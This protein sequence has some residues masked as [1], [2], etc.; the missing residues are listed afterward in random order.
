MK[1]EILFQSSEVFQPT[2]KLQMS[3][4]NCHDCSKGNSNG[5]PFSC[6]RICCSY[7]RIPGW[8]YL[9][10]LMVKAKIDGGGDF[11][12]TV[13]DATGLL[14]LFLRELPDP[15]LTSQFYHPF[16]RAYKLPGA[17]QRA[18][19]ILLLCLSLPVA[20]LHTL[21]FL[22]HLLY[23]VVHSKDSLMSASNLA[24]IFTPNIL[25]PHV[26]TET[27]TSELELA[28]HGACVGVV[29]FLIE[30]FDQVGVAPGHVQRHAMGMKSEDKARKK[31]L[32]DF[33]GK[34]ISWWFVL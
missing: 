6:V 18:E 20:H 31:F 24:A 8:M 14:K 27:A 30:H 15:L 5:R 3:L 29:E 10:A 33:M 1:K 19:A 28:N 17:Q 2:L 9:L 7:S 32:E 25:R 23:D 26:N 21:R 22:L 12:A 34:R 16:V 11:H 4:G 13:H